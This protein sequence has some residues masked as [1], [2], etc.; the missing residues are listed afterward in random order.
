[1]KLVLCDDHRIFAESLALVLEARGYVVA[2]VTETPAEALEAVIA[3]TP[4]V[5][6]IDLAFPGGDGLE[7]LRQ[8]TH[9]APSC[10][11]VVLT[12]SVDPAVLSAALDSGAAGFAVKT[13]AVDD[14]VVAIERANAREIA[15]AP[16]LLVAALAHRMATSG[17]DESES[18]RL[19]RFLTP[20]EYEVLERLVHGEDTG[21]IARGMGVA[22]STARTHIQSVLTKL[23]VHSRLEAAIVAVR[24]SIVALHP[25]ERDATL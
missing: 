13:Q 17:R 8:I 12:A 1:M 9:A 11:V 5:C 22:R 4:D 20:R 14:I 24:E 2:A 7:L 23:G 16:A 18:Q 3:S 10:R 21:T 6:V 19:A 25:D 15:V